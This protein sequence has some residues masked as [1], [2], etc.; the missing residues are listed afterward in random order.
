MPAWPA[1]AHLLL[2][3]YSESR[4]PSLL[5]TEMEDG[6]PKQA[7]IRSRA[8]VTRKATVQLRS[9]ADYQ[10]FIVWFADE[11]DEGALWFDFLDPVSKAVKQGRIVGGGAL[12][13]AAKSSLNLWEIPVQIETWG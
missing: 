7:R 3:G 13:A 6:P 4:A 10:A 11:L 5:R 2:E 12:D 9:R 8:L 1:Y